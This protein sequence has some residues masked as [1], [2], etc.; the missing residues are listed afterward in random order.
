MASFRLTEKYQS[1]MNSPI[2]LYFLVENFP[3]KLIAYM[4]LVIL[5]SMLLES[6]F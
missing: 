4:D 1:T 2:V 6:G 3:K 5:R